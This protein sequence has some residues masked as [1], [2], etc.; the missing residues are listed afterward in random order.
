MKNDPYM[1]FYDLKFIHMEQAGLMARLE[2]QWKSFK[3]MEPDVME[4]LKLKHFYLTLIGNAIGLLFS[5][6]A[7]AGE[8][9]Q[10]AKNKN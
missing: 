3:P 10:F 4:P 1:A 6:I 9:F 7:F 8:K 5:S 2:N